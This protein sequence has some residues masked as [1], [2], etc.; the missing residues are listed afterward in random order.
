MQEFGLHGEDWHKLYTPDVGR[1][2]VNAVQLADPLT[3]FEMLCGLLVP[4]YVPRIAEEVLIGPDDV[5]LSTAHEVCHN[6][7]SLGLPDVYSRAAVYQPV[8]ELKTAS[9]SVVRSLP[10]LILDKKEP[11]RQPC[12]YNGCADYRVTSFA[13]MLQLPLPP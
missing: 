1:A 5:S 8:T 2:K 7:P 4:L 3:T 13:I 9:R 6:S 12:E 11:V 10:S